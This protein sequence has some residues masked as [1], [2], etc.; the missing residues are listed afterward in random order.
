MIAHCNDI[1]TLDSVVETLVAQVLAHQAEAQ[2][3]KLPKADEPVE[4]SPEPPVETPTKAPGDEAVL[5]I[6]EAVAAPF[7][8]IPREDFV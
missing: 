5:T 6:A 1:P 7:S 4:A 3:A 8:A 2:A